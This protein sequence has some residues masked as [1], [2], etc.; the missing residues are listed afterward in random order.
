MEVI[1]RDVVKS[2][3]LFICTFFLI[4]SALW[5]VSLLERWVMHDVLT[6]DQ[7]C[8]FGLQICLVYAILKFVSIL[9]HLSGPTD[10]ALVEKG[11][12]GAIL[13]LI[14]VEHVIALLTKSLTC[15]LSCH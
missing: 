5:D 14:G 11:P 4:V 10:L 12:L 1:L 13:C 8:R 7:V 6:H 2:Y 3:N 9:S 15:E